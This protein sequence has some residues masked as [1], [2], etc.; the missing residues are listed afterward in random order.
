MTVALSQPISYLLSSIFFSCSLGSLFELYNALSTHEVDE[1][2]TIISVWQA[3]KH[4]KIQRVGT[5]IPVFWLHATSR[6]N[7]FLKEWSQCFLDVFFIYL[8]FPNWHQDLSGGT[9][10]L[11]WNC[12]DL[13]PHSLVSRISASLVHNSH[14]FRSVWPISISLI[15]I[16]IIFCWNYLFL[17]LPAT[18]PWDIL[19][20]SE[21]ISVFSTYTELWDFWQVVPLY[22]IISC[23]APTFVLLPLTSLFS[24]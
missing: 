14:K 3:R 13:L 20:Y 2:Q 5:K 1:T 18:S 12:F 4:S 9:L 24:K 10:T 7:V 19:L 23:P 22:L 15:T 8:D 17:H 6:C 21:R 16:L 11:L